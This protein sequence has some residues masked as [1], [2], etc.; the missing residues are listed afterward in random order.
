MENS[1]SKRSN[2]LG[3]GQIESRGWPG[4]IICRLQSR[5]SDRRLWLQNLAPPPTGRFWRRAFPPRRRGPLRSFGFAGK[6]SGQTLDRLLTPCGDH[7][8][9][10]AV[11]RRQL[12][13]RQFPF[14]ASNATFALK[15][16]EYRLRLPVIRSVLHKGR[17]NLKPL[18]GF[19]GPNQS[20]YT[21][22]GDT[23]VIFAQHLPKGIG[24]LRK[25]QS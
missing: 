13:Q 17:T 3:A 19:P 15:S 14:S 9:V 20:S 6:Y 12:R 8:L 24:R 22:S 21:T 4:S 2:F 10:D 1:S 18:S 16:A 7:R 23:T 11:L 25:L 5:L